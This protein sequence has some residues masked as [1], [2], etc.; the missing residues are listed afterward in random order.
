MGGKGSKQR[1]DNK[2]CGEKKE[3]KTKEHKEKPESKPQEIKINLLGT[4]E[5]PKNEF[6]LLCKGQQGDQNRCVG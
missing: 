1:K 6:G 5:M 3:K 2:K 4:D